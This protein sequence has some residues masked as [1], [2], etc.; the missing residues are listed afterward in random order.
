VSRAWSR[1]NPAIWCAALCATRRRKSQWAGV[2]KA[3]WQFEGT[4]AVAAPGPWVDSRLPLGVTD[5]EVTLTDQGLSL[6]D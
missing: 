3:T 2:Q 6:E 4:E 5:R 1:P